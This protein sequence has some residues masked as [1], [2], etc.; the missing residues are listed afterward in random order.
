MS[1]VTM[2]DKTFLDDSDQYSRF[3]WTSS[4]STDNFALTL[5]FYALYED[6][7]PEENLMLRSSYK[8]AADGG[9]LSR[10]VLVFL[11][12]RT[13]MAGKELFLSLSS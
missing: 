7:A 9:A 13:G 5:F 3:Y 1:K 2:D 8:S 11:R 10:L 4:V 6:T 12:F